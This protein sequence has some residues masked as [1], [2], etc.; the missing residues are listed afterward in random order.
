M[1]EKSTE[2][3][4]GIGDEVVMTSGEVGV[5]YAVYRKSGRYGYGIR[6]LPREQMDDF[7]EGAIPSD[8]FVVVRTPT[9]RANKG[10]RLGEGL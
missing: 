4:P 9:Q 3:R 8:G 5:V 10:L 2:R 7:P 1:K 6:V